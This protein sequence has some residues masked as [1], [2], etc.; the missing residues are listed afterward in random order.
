MVDLPLSL[1]VSKE[2]YLESFKS[3][4][5]ANSQGRLFDFSTSSVLTILGEAQALSITRLIATQLELI[6]YISAQII[7]NL[8]FIRS[9]GTYALCTVRFQLTNKFTREYTVLRGT[10]FS[11]ANNVVFTTQSDLIIPANI[12]TT[13]PANYPFCKVDAIAIELGA[14]ANQPA[15]KATI[16]QNFLELDSIWIDEPSAGGN[17]E[18][19]TEEFFDR[20]S[21]IIAKFLESTFSL[22]QASE[23]EL[24]VEAVLGNGSVAVAVPD[25][26]AD[27]TTTAI[28]SMHIFAVNNGGTP[29]TSAQIR[30]LI[31]LIAPRAPLVTGR[32]Y[33]TPLV[34]PLVDVAIS[35]KTASNEDS[36]LISDDINSRLRKVFSIGN[37]SQMSSLELYEAIH[38]VKLAG[39]LAPILT[40]GFVG[41]ILQARNL[42]LPKLSA[43]TKRTSPAKLN[44]ITVSI[45]PGGLVKLYTE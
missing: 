25:L 24:A 10:R 20:V 44:L 9:K 39:G 11:L 36:L 27:A 6:P 8:G 4:V 13:D 32:L 22:V 33:F 28:A 7:E 31:T 42:P 2:E 12:D 3:D 29:I 41:D 23:F 18:E 1:S 14:K 45:E 19:T 34:I 5:I 43:G 38:Q 35:F 17:D 37:T 30:N 16:L 15:Q 40:W 21:L 26:S